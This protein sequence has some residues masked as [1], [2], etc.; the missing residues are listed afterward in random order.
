M[1]IQS[2]DSEKQARKAFNKLENSDV[3]NELL[4]PILCKLHSIV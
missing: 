4:H 1:H 2:L 3:R